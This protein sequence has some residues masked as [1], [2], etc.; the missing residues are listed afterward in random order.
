VL[1][2]AALRPLGAPTECRLLG[3]EP[4]PRIL[5][6]QLRILPALVVTFQTP[7]DPAP[8]GMVFPVPGTISDI[9][10]FFVRPH[11]VERTMLFGVFFPVALASV[12][13]MANAGSQEPAVSTEKPSTTTEMV[14]GGASIL[15]S[16]PSTMTTIANYY[17]QN[18]YDPTDKKIGE[19]I[20]VLADGDGKIQVLIISVGG[21]LG[22]ASKDLAVPFKAVQATQRN[23][24]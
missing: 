21:F 17:K 13:L 9:K 1:A 11:G 7:N 4:R 12:A 23:G 16:I 18:V 10:A 8:P 2:S 5:W 15:T 6:G 14:T 3:Y 20:D 22:I 19:I 24:S